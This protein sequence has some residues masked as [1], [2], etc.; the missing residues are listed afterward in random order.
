MLMSAQEYR[1]TNFTPNSRPT[2]ATIKSWIKKGELAGK[3]IGRLYYVVTE[4]A[5]AAPQSKPLS[6]EPDFSKY[7][8]K[9]KKK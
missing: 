3:Q 7:E 1:E 9:S 4:D 6:T 5:A 2:L 8:S